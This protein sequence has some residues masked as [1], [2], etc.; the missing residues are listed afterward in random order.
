[1]IGEWYQAG[2]CP[3]C[4]SPIF[5]PKLDSYRGIGAPPAR[6]TCRC[7]PGVAAV[8]TGAGSVLSSVASVVSSVVGIVRPPGVR[9]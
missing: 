6:R 1:M 4:G 2:A 9:P 5:S 7:L 8:V 3:T